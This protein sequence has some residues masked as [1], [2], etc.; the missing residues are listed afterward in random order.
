MSDQTT[1]AKVQNGIVTAV[2][3]VTWEFLVENPE[4]YGNPDLYLECFQ[5]GSGRGYCAPGWLYDQQQDIF[6]NPLIVIMD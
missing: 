4:R 5:D 6:I 3:V 1:Y 2:H